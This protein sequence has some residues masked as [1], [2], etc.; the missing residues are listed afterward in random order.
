MLDLKYI[1]DKRTGMISRVVT[2]PYMGQNSH[3]EKATKE[4]FDAVLAGQP[5]EQVKPVPPPE[6]EELIF[7]E[8][9]ELGGGL[10]DGEDSS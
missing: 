5:L 6:T 10:D 7:E 1:R 8:S 4:D 3:F 2:Y 9:V